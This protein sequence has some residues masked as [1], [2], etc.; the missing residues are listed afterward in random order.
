LRIKSCYDFIKLPQSRLRDKI[1][2]KGFSA[3]KPLHLKSPAAI[4]DIDIAFQK[5]PETRQ[6]SEYNLLKT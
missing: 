3:A 4:L 6:F 2:E 1:G 5:Y